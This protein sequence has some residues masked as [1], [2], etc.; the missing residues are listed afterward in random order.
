MSPI[1][2]RMSCLNW[3]LLITKCPHLQI[4]CCHSILYTITTIPFVPWLL[5]FMAS[6]SMLLSFLTFSLLLGLFNSSQLEIEELSW[7]DDNNDEE[8]NMV[9]SRHDS[10]R[11]C[12]FV[13]GK[14]VYDQTYPLY[15]ASTC[16]Y[17]STKVTCQKNGRP[18]SDYEKWRWKPHGCNI[19]R[20]VYNVF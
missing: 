10:L 17:L 18:D 6:S 5:T 2:H 15:D 3:T 1:H 12:D 4:F 11:K 16:P 13:S 19:P 20:Y 9:Q 7:L 14:W 8:I